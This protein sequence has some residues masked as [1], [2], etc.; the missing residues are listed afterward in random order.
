VEQLEDAFNERLEEVRAY[1]KFLEA[2]EA[3]A[4]HGPPRFHDSLDP[5]TP[6]QQKLLYASVYLHLYSLVEATMTL[7][8]ESVSK[9]T[10]MNAN[11]R[12]EDLSDAL[13][14]E[15][16]RSSARTHIDLNYENRLEAVIGVV[17]H[18]MDEMP[19][20]SFSIERGGGGN[21]DDQ[22]IEK[23]TSRL[24]CKLQIKR[25]VQ[26]KVKRPVK[27]DLGALALVKKMRNGLAHGDI[28]FADSADQV[29]AAE[30]A[31]LA[32]NVIAYLQEVVNRFKGFI[33]Q[34]EFLVPERRPTAA[35]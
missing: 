29:S 24:G 25:S 16:V 4:Q 6:Q 8:V 11:W 34:Y 32:Q 18:L 19:V 21:W 20:T 27:D 15:W 3:Q 30:L 12:P 1:L 2:M 10:E 33:D 22:A 5:V 23:M 28:S 17:T 13:R 7:C 9:A 14:R 35:A 31:S 26:S